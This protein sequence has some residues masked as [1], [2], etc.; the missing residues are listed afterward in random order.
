MRYQTAMKNCSHH[1][2]DK[3]SEGSMRFMVGFVK[4][5]MLADTV[6]PLADM[7]FGAENPMFIDAWLGVLAYT[8]QL[9]FDFSGY[10]D[11]A[12]GLGLMLGFRFPENFNHPYISKSITEFWQRW[13][14]S[15]STWLRDYLYIPLGGNRKGSGRTY[16]NLMTVMLLGGL[17]HGA[18]WTFV[19]WG[20][21]HGGLLAL[22]RL[23]ASQKLWRPLPAFIT[24]PKTLILAMI[25][26]VT[27]RATDVSA[28]W[29]VYRG[30]L[31]LNGFG[32]N[33]SIAWQ[34]HGF[35]I[36]M[37][38]LGLVLVYVAPWWRD[39]LSKRPIPQ[40]RSWVNI[41]LFIIPIFVLAILRLSAQNFSPFLYFQF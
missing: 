11:M 30:M 40:Q 27:F 17:W 35:H 28:A 23:L 25:G 13:H 41:H 4:K 31:G 10:S 14:I 22:E 19:L 18:N 2:L 37:L 7:V 15:L 36:S 29:K 39:Y 26:W 34:I 9:Y 24:M 38:V 5:V 32:I 6:A 33:K 20:A 1:T 16:V 12:I 3:F 21:W 8:L